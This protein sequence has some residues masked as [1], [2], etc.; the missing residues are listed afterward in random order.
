MMKK[1]KKILIAMLLII[2]FTSC[3]NHESSPDFWMAT[4]QALENKFDGNSYN[5]GNWQINVQDKSQVED[6]DH[7]ALTIRQIHKE[8]NSSKTTMFSLQ[9]ENDKKTI[10]YIY[11]ISKINDSNHNDQTITI[12][13]T[14]EGYQKY[15]IIYTNEKYQDN[16]YKDGTEAKGKL[17]IDANNKIT[18]DN[19]PLLKEALNACLLLLNDFQKEFDINYQ[20]YD[21]VDLPKLTENLDIPDISEISEVTSQTIDYYSDAHINAKGFSLIT[22]L[23]IEKDFSG[24]QFGIYNVERKDYETNATVTFE[25]RSMEQ[26]YNIVQ[27]NDPDINYA[28]YFIDDAT[29]YIYFQSKTDEEIK[30]DVLNQASSQ[31][32]TVLKTTNASY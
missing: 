29:A 18:Y 32:V 5:E 14:D 20:D 12:Q 1:L 3:G 8:Q 30:D 7:R 13:S 15:E 9:N 27:K 2:P 4:I 11:K 19:V 24:A 28:V 10:S 17:N 21:F 16:N 6:E 25:K 31:A 22:F 26:C 23:K